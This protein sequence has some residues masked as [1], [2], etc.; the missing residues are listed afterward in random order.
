M[1]KSRGGSSSKGSFLS[2]VL[3][4]AATE[5]FLNSWVTRYDDIT[6]K[7]NGVYHGVVEA[8]QSKGA[9]TVVIGEK[10]RGIPLLCNDDWLSNGVKFAKVLLMVDRLRPSLDQPEYDKDTILRD[11]IKEGEVLFVVVEESRKSPDNIYKYIASSAFK[12]ESSGKIMGKSVMLKIRDPL[13]GVVE[14]YVSPDVGV[15]R[16]GTY[17]G[18]ISKAL[19]TSS[20]FSNSSK[21]SGGDSSLKSSVPV[22]SLVYLEVT[23]WLGASRAQEWE[24]LLHK[25]GIHFKATLVWLKDTPRPNRA[26]DEEGKQSKS[27]SGGQNKKQGSGKPAD[28]KSPIFDVGMQ[29]PEYLLTDIQAYYGVVEI[30]PS[31]SVAII[32][33]AHRKGKPISWAENWFTKDVSLERILLISDHVRTSKNEPESAKGT[34]IKSL[35]QIGEHVMVVVEPSRGADKCYKWFAKTCWKVADGGQRKPQIPLNLLI[36]HLCGQVES[37]ISHDTGVIAFHTYH[38]H[39]AKAFFSHG[40]Y[41][42]NGKKI[43]P[44]IPLGS[45]IVK[46][47]KVHLIPDKWHSRRNPK[48]VEEDANAKDVQFRAVVVWP[49]G[50]FRPNEND[51]AENKEQM[52]AGTKPKLFTLQQGGQKGSVLASGGQEKKSEFKKPGRGGNQLGGNRGGGGRRGNRGA[53]GNQQK[54]QSKNDDSR[55]LGD[56]VDLYENLSELSE[57]LGGRSSSTENLYTASSNV[58]EWKLSSPNVAS[59]GGSVRNEKKSAQAKDMIVP[60]H[61]VT[62]A[63]T[64]VSVDASWGLMQVN[65]EDIVDFKSSDVYMYGLKLEGVPL[66]QLFRQGQSFNVHMDG[67]KVVAVE[68]GA[69]QLPHLLRKAILLYCEQNSISESVKYKVESII[70]SHGL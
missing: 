2:N 9:A 32:C 21:N 25:D 61:D 8:I 17:N 50:T 6:F 35:L 33:T 15:V 59:G 27:S 51:G 37:I 28:S 26:G 69:P 7:C 18:C 11:K 10:E 62:R 49:L 24:K 54:G 14:S 66:H 23:K 16:F 42:K 4:S 46:G 64:L 65:G 36:G 12:M 1:A 3:D 53:G 68:Y 19:F 29:K 45:E 48:G 43:L 52:D 67:E 56:W 13:R 31:T 38:G 47:T 44:H 70:E 39:P 5:M 63:G 22:L 60:Q 20:C 55:S 40:S 30:I 58:S 57:Y 41:Y 34:P